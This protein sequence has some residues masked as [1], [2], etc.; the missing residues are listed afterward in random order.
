[1]KF[2]NIV[3]DERNT[4]NQ[5]LYIDIEEPSEYPGIVYYYPDGITKGLFRKKTYIASENFGL[6]I[7]DFLVYYETLDELIKKHNT[8]SLFIE[9]GEVYNCGRICF[10]FKDI[11]ENIIF[12]YRNNS[13][14]KTYLENLSDKYS[15]YLQHFISLEEKYQMSLYEYKEKLS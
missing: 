11:E 3:D 12:R 15:F 6:G 14:L 4:F 13:E 7:K 5:L 2:I 10:K 9:N 8:E 1:M